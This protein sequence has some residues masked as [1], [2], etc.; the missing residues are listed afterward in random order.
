MQLSFLLV[1]THGK[2]GKTLHALVL[3]FHLL[4]DEILVVEKALS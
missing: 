2:R 3:R 4:Q 1:W